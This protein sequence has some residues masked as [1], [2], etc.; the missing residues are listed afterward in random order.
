MNRLA[1]V[2]FTVAILLAHALAIHQDPAGDYAAPYDFAHVGYRVARNLVREGSFAWNPGG[3]LYQSY[4]SPAWV[5]LAAVAERLTIG[6]N[7]LTQAFGTLCVLASVFVLA[8]FSAKRMGGLIA[9]LLL[10]A[11]GAA[12]AAGGSGTEAGLAMLLVTTAALAFERRGP[13]VFAA[14]TALLM[15]TRPEAIALVAVAFLHE[16]VDRPRDALGVRGRAMRR[17]FLAP[18]GAW[19]ALALVRRL[20][21][22]VWL[23]PLEREA[24]ELDGER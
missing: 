16:L 6:P 14:S 15:W 22:G 23:S 9:P 4:P 21:T 8:Q 17:A 19:V 24:L 2:L 10:A 12:A 3:A 5:L 20:S 11:S 18:L 7:Q 1:V 13:R